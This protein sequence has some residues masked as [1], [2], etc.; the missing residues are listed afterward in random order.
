MPLPLMP[1]SEP[2]E[3]K[4]APAQ[5]VVAPQSYGVPGCNCRECRELND[6]VY[7]T[8][9]LRSTQYGAFNPA[10][11]NL[12]RDYPR[13][14]APGLVRGRYD[15]SQH[16]GV[17]DPMHGLVRWLD[18]RTGECFDSGGVRQWT[19]TRLGDDWIST[20]T[21]VRFQPDAPTATI[22]PTFDWGLAT[23]A[24]IHLPDQLGVNAGRVRGQYDPSHP[25]SEL[26]R[27]CPRWLSTADGRLYDEYGN[28]AN[29]LSLVDGV[30]KTASGLV[31]VPV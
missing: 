9:T 7:G 27:D 20:R 6:R 29:T 30:W 18:T 24:P 15:F 3:L 22:A 23:S 10:P 5:P 21:G 16:R 8:Q 12:P 11:Q 4:Y 13:G 14:H 19:F 2:V 1:G 28:Q 26:F 17:T 31:W 25:D